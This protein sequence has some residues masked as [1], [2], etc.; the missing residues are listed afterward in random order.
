MGCFDCLSRNFIWYSNFLFLIAGLA[1]AGLGIGIYNWDVV[2][3]VGGDLAVGVMIF[4]GFIVFLSILALCGARKG[5]GKCFMYLYTF[6]LAIL[7]IAQI[8]VGVIAI[9]KESEGK[10]FLL[11]RWDNLSTSEQAEFMEKTK[12][13]ANKAD[14]PIN[15]DSDS[16]A[17][18][19]DCYDK[20]KDQFTSF[21]NIVAVVGIA[22][23]AFEM[24]LLLASCCLLCTDEDY[25]S[26][27]EEDNTNF[28]V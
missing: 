16:N 17:C 26:D 19:E 10:D 11:K 6:V 21:T 1:I 18:F 28:Q 25:N 7:I 8:A 24:L 27:N 3:W 23:A 2:D 15:C 4:G 5:A 9:T 12:C 22:V 14:A 20:V 13:G